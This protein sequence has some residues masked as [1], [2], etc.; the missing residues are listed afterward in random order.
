MPGGYDLKVMP[1]GGDYPGVEVQATVLQNIMDGSAIRPAP[2]WVGL[3]MLFVVFLSL[4]QMPAPRDGTLVEMNK[5]NAGPQS[6]LEIISKRD[7]DYSGATAPPY[8]LYLL[9]VEHEP[10]LAE[11]DSAF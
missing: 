2:P 1:Y 9:K 3:A 10:R 5:K 7:R 6:I 4:G 8:G 11:L